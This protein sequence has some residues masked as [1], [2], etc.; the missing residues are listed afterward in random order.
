MDSGRPPGF[1]TPRVSEMIRSGI[2]YASSVNIQSYDKKFQRK[3]SHTLSNHTTE[4]YPH[5]MNTTPVLPTQVVPVVDMEV[6]HHHRRHLRAQLAPLETRYH[7]LCLGR[8]LA[9]LGGEELHQHSS[10][11]ELLLPHLVRCCIVQRGSAA[12]PE[13]GNETAESHD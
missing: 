11:S 6:E 8:S 7:L 3:T 1:V 5:H 2:R 4:R 13:T 12:F 9:P 10:P